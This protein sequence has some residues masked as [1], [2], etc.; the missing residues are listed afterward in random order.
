MHDKM[1]K[2]VTTRYNK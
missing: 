2:T 1:F